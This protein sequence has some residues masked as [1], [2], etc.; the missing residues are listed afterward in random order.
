MPIKKLL[1]L[2]YM[3]DNLSATSR[4]LT[5]AVYDVIALSVNT[6]TAVEAPW[7]PAI[8]DP[9]KVFKLVVM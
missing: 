6:S 4:M 5:T 8:T 3:Q 7:K 2:K 1:Q 9:D